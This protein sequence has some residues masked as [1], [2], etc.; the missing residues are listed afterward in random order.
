MG[1][2]LDLFGLNANYPRSDSLRS[3]APSDAFASALPGQSFYLEDLHWGKVGMGSK[4]SLSKA[5]PEDLW[6][7][8]RKSLNRAKC[9]LSASGVLSE[10]VQCL[11]AATSTGYLSGFS[12]TLMIR[13]VLLKRIAAKILTSQEKLSF[14]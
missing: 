8:Q 10:C 6:C 1:I 11:L 5:F 9:L 3:S 7:G 13:K 12:A 14:H 2:E 4:L